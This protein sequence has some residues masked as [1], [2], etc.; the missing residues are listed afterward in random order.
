MERPRATLRHAFC[1][2]Y[3][4]RNEPPPILDEKD[5]CDLS[6]LSQNARDSLFLLRDRLDRAGLLEDFKRGDGLSVW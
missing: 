2:T 4:C 3:L 1:T 5:T 6:G